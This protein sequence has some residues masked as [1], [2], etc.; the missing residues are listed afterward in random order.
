[1]SPLPLIRSTID[2]VFGT[3]VILEGA[4]FGG[5]VGCCRN[6]IKRLPVGAVA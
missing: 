2:P 3:W 1:M 6:A 5:A 4:W